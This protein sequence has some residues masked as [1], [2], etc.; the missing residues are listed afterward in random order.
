MEN[1]KNTR[2]TDDRPKRVLD[3]LLKEKNISK[4]AAS[5]AV[6]NEKSYI[7]NF[8]AKGS[9]KR[10]G[11]D[12]RKILGRLL[13]CSP[14]EFLP[15]EEYAALQDHE[16][17]TAQ[18][19]DH[20]QAPYTPNALETNTRKADAL[21]DGHTSSLDVPLMGT[22]ECGEGDYFDMGGDGGNV[23]RPKDLIGNHEA[24]AIYAV[25][26]SMKTTIDPGDLIYADPT[27]KGLRN[28]YI[29]IVQV[30]NGDGE[31]ITKALLKEYVKQTPTTLHLRSVNMDFDQDI[32]IPR[33]HVKAIHRARWKQGDLS[34]DVVG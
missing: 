1:S 9:P 11:D 20:P 29:V 33:E 2:V 14:D 25:G 19:N 28:G 8:L 32:Q 10:L 30:H 7:Y 22:A 21:S 34:G 4:K 5:L 26:E 6:G 18:I 27:M 16:L 31:T 13:D 12:V 17:S 15:G 23:T 3:Q 24:Y